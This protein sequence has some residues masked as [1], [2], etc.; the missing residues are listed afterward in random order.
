VSEVCAYEVSIAG[1]DW[2]PTV[3]NQA[4]RGKAKRERFLSL[5]DAGW[6][7]PWTM[8]RARK[9]GSRATSAAFLRVAAM[10]GLP[11]LRCGSRVVAKDGTW[12]GTVTGHNDSCNF[13]VLIDGRDYS[14][15]VHPSE[16]DVLPEGVAK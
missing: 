10:R 12:K 9:M 11:N 3:I 14:G 13:E 4:S 8:L 16:F 7:F 15:N 6:E 5:Q 2:P 1:V